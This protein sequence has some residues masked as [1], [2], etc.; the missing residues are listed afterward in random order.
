[1]LKNFYG[2][3][4]QNVSAEYVILIALASIA[5][6]TMTTY[7]R[8]ALQGRYRDA[9]GAIAHKASQALG[10]TVPIEYEPY[11]VNTTADTD[12]S[13]FVQETS[14]GGGVMDRVDSLDRSV[15]SVSTQK[16]F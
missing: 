5:I 16:P 14:A 3:K 12:S 1:M 11:Y 10:N 6:V 4:G 7:V 15:N 8:R 9:N 13:S 2:K